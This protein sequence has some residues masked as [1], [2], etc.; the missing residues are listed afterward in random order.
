MRKEKGIFFFRI[1]FHSEHIRH[2]HELTFQFVYYHSW[3]VN[4]VAWRS[5]YHTIFF[6]SSVDS[7]TDV[8]PNWMMKFFNF[9]R[10]L[11]VE[12]RFQ[13]R[14]KNAD[15]CEKERGKIHRTRRSNN[16]NTNNNHWNLSSRTY[17]RQ[18]KLKWTQ[19]KKEARNKKINYKMKNEPTEKKRMNIFFLFRHQIIGRISFEWIEQA[20]SVSLSCAFALLN[21]NQNNRRKWF[22]HTVKRTY[23]RTLTLTHENAMWR[24][25]GWPVSLLSTL[26][27]DVLAAT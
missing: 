7:P 19:N 14:M 23:T 4:C 21:Q 11:D 16:N 20:T 8:V 6:F 27:T 13:C 24:V 18:I 5:D 9:F 2:Q 17:Q 26:C 12:R 10:C 15:E 22:A 1:S 25:D 3:N